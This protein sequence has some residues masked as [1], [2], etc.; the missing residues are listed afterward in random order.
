[1]A[2]KKP[3]RKPKNKQPVRESLGPAGKEQTVRGEPGEANKL[4][5]AERFREREKKGKGGPQQ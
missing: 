3:D 4:T 5:S 1:M 2:H